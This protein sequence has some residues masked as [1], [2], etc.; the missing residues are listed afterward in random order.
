MWSERKR[1]FKRFPDPGSLQQT[2]SNTPR[3]LLFL[4]CQHNAIFMLHFHCYFDVQILLSHFL[5]LKRFLIGHLPLRIFCVFS[6]AHWYYCYFY[7]TWC[8]PESERKKFGLRKKFIKA[9]EKDKKQLW[10]DTLGEFEKTFYE[11]F[12]SI[13]GANFD[14][15]SGENWKFVAATCDISS[16][17]LWNSSKKYQDIFIKFQTRH[18]RVS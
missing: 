18:Q 8:P 13:V 11:P 12:K 1:N 5:I 6:Y 17:C 7:R 9:N 10:K 2:H 15:C 14:A 16:D 4:M 3:L